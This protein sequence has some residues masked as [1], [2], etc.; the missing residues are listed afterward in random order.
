VPQSLIVYPAEL[1]DE[2]FANRGSIFRATA[3]AISGDVAGLGLVKF[4]G[5]MPERTEMM[6]L[7][8][9]K[10]NPNADGGDDPLDPPPDIVELLRIL[11]QVAHLPPL[12]FISFAFLKVRHGSIRSV[13]EAIAQN[14]DGRTAVAVA[15]G[16]Q[17]NVVVEIVGDDHQEVLSR[18]LDIVDRPEVESMRTLRT[19]RALTVGFGDDGTVA[20]AS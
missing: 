14:D 6:S 18:L 20:P 7:R 17:F 5:A 2:W 12:D 4:D 9:K 1:K 3:T 15:F 13:A 19:S 8:S 11:G 10:L 16:A